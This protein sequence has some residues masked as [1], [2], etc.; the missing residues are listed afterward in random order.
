M[1]GYLVALIGFTVVFGLSIAA[2][3]V[4]ASDAE[5]RGER[6]VFVFLGIGFLSIA[7]MIYMVVKMIC[8]FFQ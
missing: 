3:A 8:I 7:S 1:L 4:A 2:A 5:G 6:A